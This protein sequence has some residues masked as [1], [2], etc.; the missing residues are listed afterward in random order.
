MNANKKTVPVHIFWEPKQLALNELK[1]PKNLTYFCFAPFFWLFVDRSQI[2][3]SETQKLLKPPSLH[4]FDSKI[5]SPAIAPLPKA[6]LI[7][8]IK[9]DFTVTKIGRGET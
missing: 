7:K 9:P 6:S 5:V 8:I 4:L 1:L 3:W 2:W